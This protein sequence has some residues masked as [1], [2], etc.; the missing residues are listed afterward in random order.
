MVVNSFHLDDDVT[1]KGPEPC[2]NPSSPKEDGLMY[3]LSAKHH[4]M[5]VFII[6][7]KIHRYNQP[8]NLCESA[9]DV[10][11]CIKLGFFKMWDFCQE[12]LFLGLL[13]I[14]LSV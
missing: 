7:Y 6:F 3:K 12:G 10:M 14:S 4:F 1:L 2:F 11:V 13:F 5:K 8:S 9:I